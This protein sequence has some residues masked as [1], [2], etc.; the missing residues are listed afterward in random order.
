M[1]V[2]WLVNSSAGFIVTDTDKPIQNDNLHLSGAGILLHPKEKALAIISLPKPTQNL[3]NVE[4]LIAGKKSGMSG[5][6]QGVDCVFN[7][8]K[9][10]SN[11]EGQQTAANL[12]YSLYE[13]I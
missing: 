12:Q 8:R 9:F 7:P 10:P 11:L 2:K 5:V 3:L 6:S 13:F 4:D 1:Q